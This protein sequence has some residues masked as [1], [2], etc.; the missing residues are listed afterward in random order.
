MSEN[1]YIYQADIWC[2]Q[3]TASIKHNLL[4]DV[5]GWPGIIDQGG[6]RYT[7]EAHKLVQENEID[8]PC[9]GWDIDIDRDNPVDEMVMVVLTEPQDESLYDSGEWPKGPYGNGGGEANSPQHCGARD[10]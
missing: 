1:A 6:G 2:E 8:L 4:M 7:F 10:D 5:V 9:S 3:C